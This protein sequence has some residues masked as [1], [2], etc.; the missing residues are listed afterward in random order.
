M[1][2]RI[3]IE[4]NQGSRGRHCA[5]SNGSRP[6]KLQSLA[7]LGLLA[8]PLAH[9][10]SLASH[11]VAPQISHADYGD[12]NIVMPLSTGDE[13]TWE[14]RM[15]HAAN[16]V[17]TASQWNGHAHVVIVVYGP[18]IQLLTHHNDELAGKVDK[19][20]SMG[21]VFKAC[22]N[23]MKGFDLNWHELNNVAEAD[24]VPAGILEVP[25]LEQKGYLLA[26]E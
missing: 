2:R 22:N 24:I 3:A 8:L 26:S 16:A 18:A 21:V 12:M 19:L 7:L 4:K 11:Y 23:S 6:M 13:A 25:Y 9:A 10:Q 17:A 20:R 5:I 15:G 14:A 1:L